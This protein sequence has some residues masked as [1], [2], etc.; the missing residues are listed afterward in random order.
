MY[1]V[2]ILKSQHFEETYVGYTKNLKARL[3]EHN[4]GKSKHTSKFKPWVVIWYCAFE[5][6]CIAIDF[7][8]YLKSGSGKAFTMK[9]LL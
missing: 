4:S 7:E 8:K 2:Y 3:N 9:H 1:Y 6:N 5:D